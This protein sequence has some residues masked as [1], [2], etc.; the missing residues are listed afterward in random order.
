MIRAKKYFLCAGFAQNQN[1][2]QELKSSEAHKLSW[3]DAVWNACLDLSAEDGSEKVA[4]TNS[5][6]TWSTELD[7]LPSGGP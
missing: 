2:H 5:S 3:P 6:M 7:K 1:R 4:M